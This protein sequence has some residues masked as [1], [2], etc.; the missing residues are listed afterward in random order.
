[1]R[2]LLFLFLLLNN[3]HVF[4]QLDIYL[5]SPPYN[6]KTA[7]IDNYKRPYFSNIISLD[8]GF[9][10]SF[11]D[12]QADEKDYYYK[13][14]RFDEHWNPSQIQASEYI[15]GFDSDIITNM[16]QSTGTL[17][18]YMHYQV[19]FPNEN[20]RIV[21]SGNYIIQILDDEDRVVFSKYFILYK[22]QIEAGIQVRWPEN[23]SMQKEK[24]QVD[25]FL[26]PGST[27]IQNEAENLS[28]V[29]L[30]NDNWNTKKVYHAP[31]YYQGNKWI[32]HFPSNSLFDGLNE[33]RRFETKDVRGMNYNIVKREK[34]DKLY[35]F[36]IYPDA[37][38]KKYTYYKDA[39]GVFYILSVQAQ[40]NV[41]IEADYVYVHFSYNGKLKE[42]EKIYVTGRFNNFLPGAECE[43]KFNTETNFYEA[44][45]L[46]KQGYYEYMY[47]VKNGNK[48]SYV[49]V[50][51]NFSET[52]N[53]YDLIIY[54][55]AP[56][57]RYTEVIGHAYTNSINLE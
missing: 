3:F 10:L 17:Q 8:K 34:T 57:K 56:G 44:V 46:L 16:K 55:R 47:L 25:F 24:Q 23:V 9:R 15:E 49:P 38:R 52:E 41:N 30:Q 14:L 37:P 31:T 2:K 45:L 39:D 53:R 7:W 11:D 28:I 50:E 21:L 12:L 43:L 18:S 27:T 42:K 36:Y 33:F 54:Y 19:S 13:I 1:M 6:I 22:K 48:M 40:E 26:Y 5:V 35:D 20:T 51:G 32:Y 29:L 4:S